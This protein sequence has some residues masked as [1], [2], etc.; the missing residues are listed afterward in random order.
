MSMRIV[1]DHA[2]DTDT[3]RAWT[4]TPLGWLEDLRPWIATTTYSD[5]ME[6]RIDFETHAQA[7]GFAAA[8]TSSPSAKHDPRRVR[9]EKVTG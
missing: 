3:G 9:I 6:H 1:G 8:C 7:L 5:G 4:R 2:T